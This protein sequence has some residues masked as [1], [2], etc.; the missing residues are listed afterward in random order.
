MSTFLCGEN[1]ALAP[2]APPTRLSL[3]APAALGLSEALDPQPSTVGV[4]EWEIIRCSSYNRTRV[5]AVL[6]CAHDTQQFVVPNAGIQRCFHDKVRRF[7]QRVAGGIREV[8]Q[9]ATLTGSN[10]NEF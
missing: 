10:A 2:T 9:A 8:Q 6:E 3:Y 4:A 7:V 5:Q 1:V